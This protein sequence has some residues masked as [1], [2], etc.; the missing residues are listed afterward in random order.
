MCLNIM[1]ITSSIIF[2]RHLW[3]VVLAA[4]LRHHLGLHFLDQP[5]TLLPR[6]KRQKNAVAAG[7]RDVFP[8]EICFCLLLILGAPATVAN[9]S[10]IR[11][12]FLLFLDF[13]LKCYNIF[14]GAGTHMQ[15][16]I[17]IKK[18]YR[19]ICIYLH[20]AKTGIY[21]HINT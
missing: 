17:P 19:H 14:I 18:P 6:R 10:L 16:H 2:S 21:R 5:A 20:G 11:V 3:L 12:W 1:Q 9:C 4:P 13:S 7:S 15:D 8:T